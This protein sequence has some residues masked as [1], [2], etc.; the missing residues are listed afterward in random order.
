MYGYLGGVNVSWH[1]MVG[2]PEDIYI[3]NNTVVGTNQNSNFITVHS[4]SS[5]VVIKNNIFYND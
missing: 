4:G 2:T 1:P 5:P 3:Y